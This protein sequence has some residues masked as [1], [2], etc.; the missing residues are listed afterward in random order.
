MV[1]WLFLL[2]RRKGQN[3]LSAAEAKGKAETI[4]QYLE[5]R[6]GIESQA[7]QEKVRTIRDLKVLGRITNKIFVV[8]NFDE[9]SALVEDYLVSR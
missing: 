7:L 4:C 9:A 2:E 8:A 6:F 3:S 5:V 1:R